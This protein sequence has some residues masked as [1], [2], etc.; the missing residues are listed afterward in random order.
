[1]N[2]DTRTASPFNAQ[3]ILWVIAAGILGV[4]AFLFLSTYAPELNQGDDG[5][6]HALSKSAIGYSALV[7]LETELGNKPELV[8]DE[9]DLKNAG[10]LILT[11][12]VGQD[13][14]EIEK[15]I[16]ARNGQPTFIILP[17][18]E[19][20]PDLTHTGWVSDG[21]LTPTSEVQKL[22]AKVAPVSVLRTRTT[23][24]ATFSDHPAPVMIFNNA[25]NVQ[26]ISGE[27]LTPILTDD[28]SPDTSKNSII[29]GRAENNVFILADPDLLNNLG[30]A[31]P[32]RAYAATR[33]L[34]QMRPSNDPT[35]TFDLTLNGFKQSRGLLD[36]VVRPPFLALTIALIVAAIMALLN[37]L[38]RFGPPMVEARAIPRGKGALVENTA[39]MLKL[40]KVEHQLGGRYAALIR[41]LAGA[42]QGLPQGMSAEAMTARL[43]SLTKQGAPFSEL[44]S[45]AEAAKNRTALLDAAQQ[46]DHW[47]KGN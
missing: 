46:L 20:I 17:K 31:D 44:A 24:T 8:R 42:Q 14:G 37:G 25:P 45:R 16:A 47:R 15:I 11:P 35:I 36:L 2:T 27:E 33:I 6:G 21:G 13:A 29:I 30:L 5:R 9:D 7:K 32:H 39:D 40:A 12:E 10:L 26:I 18:H 23:S 3:V 38:V 28:Q 19:T 4:I 22:L 43:D 1:M 41:E 34:D